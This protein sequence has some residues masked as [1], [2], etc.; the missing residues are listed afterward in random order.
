MQG[1]A[2]SPVLDS[3]IIRAGRA[4]VNLRQGYAIRYTQQT[5]LR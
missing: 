4:A 5:C 2:R 1:R 3:P